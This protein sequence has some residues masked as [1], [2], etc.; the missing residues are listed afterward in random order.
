ME[1]K[2]ETK[3]TMPKWFE[4]GSIIGVTIAGNPLVGY[5]FYELFKAIH[6]EEEIIKTKKQTPNNRVNY[7]ELLKK[8]NKSL[9][10]SIISTSLGVVLLISPFI[11][12]LFYKTTSKKIDHYLIEKCESYLPKEEVL[13]T[14]II[15]KALYNFTKG[16]KEEEIK[17]YL[18][19]SLYC[20]VYKD[21][22]KKEMEIRTIG[23]TSLTLDHRTEN[24]IKEK[25]WS[26]Y[27]K[28][29]KEKD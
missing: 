12:G 8:R 28:F 19:P 15:L 25:C 5:G 18:N 9:K 6:Y 13:P 10:K 23:S 16:K 11:P 24:K 2:D 29:K 21:R 26:L 3:N 27:K 22:D 14:S 17:I 7:K 1:G 20:D 4:I